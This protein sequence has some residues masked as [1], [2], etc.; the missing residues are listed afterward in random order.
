MALLQTV[1]FQFNTDFQQAC[2]I[3]LVRDK[4]KGAIFLNNKLSNP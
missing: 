1:T 3:S 4:H 2:E